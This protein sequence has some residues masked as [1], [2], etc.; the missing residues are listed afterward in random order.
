MPTF[1]VYGYMPLCILL[2]N[3][4]Q[5]KNIPWVPELLYIVVTSVAASLMFL[6]LVV[7]AFLS[8]SPPSP[9]YSSLRRLAQLKSLSVVCL[10]VLIFGAGPV[11]D[12]FLCWADN[13]AG[14]WG[15]G[16]MLVPAFGGCDIAFWGLAQYMD[17]KL[18]RNNNDRNRQYVPI[19]KK[20]K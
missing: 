13:V 4:S 20:S 10:G 16:N 17:L 8:S 11:A 5:V 9:S 1:S 3:L 7:P 14:G 2:L 19:T 15:W 12:R 18:S 6:L